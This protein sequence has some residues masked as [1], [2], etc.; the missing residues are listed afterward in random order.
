MLMN[1]NYLFQI[2]RNFADQAALNLCSD[3]RRVILLLFSI[4]HQLIKV[5]EKRDE[6][7]LVIR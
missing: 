3:T 2:Y 1:Q 6:N 4:I 5:T 7:K